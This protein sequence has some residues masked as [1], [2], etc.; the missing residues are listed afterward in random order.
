MGRKD[1]EQEVGKFVSGQHPGAGQGQVA[2][3]AERQEVQGYAGPQH[4]KVLGAKGTGWAP[5]FVRK[6]ILN[7]HRD[8][9]EEVKKE[10]TFFNDFL[11]D[12]KRPSL[13][14]L[15]L[16]PLPGPGQGGMG[17]NTPFPPSRGQW[18]LASR[19]HLSW[20]LEVGLL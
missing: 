11:M 1:P 13:P 16:P 20:A 8:K 17:P 6:H 4:A 10:V 3:S 9:I 12:A 15:K 5:E 19:D 18:A 2:V 7:K 14:E